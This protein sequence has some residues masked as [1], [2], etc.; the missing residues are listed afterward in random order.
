MRR[1]LQ[2]RGCDGFSKF[3]FANGM[4]NPNCSLWESNQSSLFLRLP[5]KYRAWAPLRG[6]GWGPQL[7][8]GLKGAV[9]LKGTDHPSAGIGANL[10]GCV[11]ASLEVESLSFG[12]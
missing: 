9:L 10:A 4:F 2:E 6:R 5:A 11:W 8:S 7:L 1:V 3:C 12:D